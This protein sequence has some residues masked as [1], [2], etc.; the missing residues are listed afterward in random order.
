MLALVAALAA[1]LDLVHKALTVEGA[2]VHERSALW[3][4]VFGVLACVEAGA[5]VLTRSTGL[6][7]A[8]GLLVGGCAANLV[9]AA[10]WG[11]VPDPIA[12]AGFYLSAGDVLIATGIAALVPV[13]YVVG[14]RELAADKAPESGVELATP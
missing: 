9:S 2:V 10:I 3:I 7:L 13:A 11:G 12:F 6:A 1:S 8:G 4:V 14:R 5:I